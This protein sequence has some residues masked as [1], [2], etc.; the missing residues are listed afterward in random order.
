MKTALDMGLFFYI[1]CTSLYYLHQEACI[2]LWGVKG[3]VVTAKTI[4]N[5][6]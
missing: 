4:G 1:I 3:A 2:Y 6:L 5:M